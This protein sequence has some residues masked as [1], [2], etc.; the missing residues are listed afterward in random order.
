MDKKTY[1]KQMA[2]EAMNSADEARR[3]T[4]LPYLAT[5]VNARLNKTRDSFWANAGVFF[6][7]PSIAFPALSLLIMVNIAAVYFYQKD[8]FSNLTEQV[9]NDN[10]DEFSEA[11]SSIYD[12]VNNEQ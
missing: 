8:S 11:N 2:N 5:R 1:I 10:T 4:P 3:A 9:S 7:R 6:S 12:I